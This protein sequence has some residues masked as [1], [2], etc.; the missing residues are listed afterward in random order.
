MNT[1][2]NQIVQ[3][4]QDS[5][6][7]AIS[8]V[9]IELV[10]LYWK[11]GAYIS[12]QLQQANWGEKT[13]GE[14]AGYIKKNHPEIKGF[15]RRGLYRM[16]Q[17]YETYAGT[18][19]ISLEENTS[20]NNENEPLVIVSPVVTQLHLPD[21]KNCLLTKINWTN[22]LIILS[23]CQSHEE[24]E[25]YI[26]LCVREKYSKRELERQINSSIFERSVSTLQISPTL[27]ERQSEITNIFKD[28]YVFEFL[29]LP[30]P[31]QEDQLQ[32]AL[33]QQ[34]K[35]F[36]LELGRDFLFV[37]EEFKLQVGNADFYVDLLFYHRGLQCL[38]AVEL[39]A[40]RFRP[41]HIG[42]LNFYLEALDRDVKKENE[43]P[44][45][46]VLLCKDKD[47]EVVEYALSRNLSP[48]LVA[49][50]K[51]QLPD[52]KVLQKKLHDIFREK[53]LP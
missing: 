35:L 12:L 47:S 29:N 27:K 22:H 37:A 7:K 30:E 53:E 26:R 44:S 34:M 48:A 8:A 31:V 25:F 46:G 17:F 10:H 11:V 2:F 14:L 1:Q 49:E 6:N 51:M 52:K 41:E 19:L 36:V 24:R 21:A 9:N 15:D 20:Q 33:I 43:N 45:I 42:Q 32:Q 18:P 13:V 3:I 38:V 39:K 16:K 5:R 23:R 28:R 40:D 4:I 50:Y